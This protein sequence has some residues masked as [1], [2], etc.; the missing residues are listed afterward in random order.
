MPESD[1]P[2]LYL[3]QTHGLLPLRCQLNQLCKGV[4]KYISI[5]VVDIWAIYRQ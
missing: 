4:Y 3:A 1:Q 5:I 2:F